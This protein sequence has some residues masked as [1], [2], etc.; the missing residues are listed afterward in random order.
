MGRGDSGRHSAGL[1][2]GHAGRSHLLNRRR[3]HTRRLSALDRARR[4]SGRHGRR[5][6]ARSRR[7]LNRPLG[8]GLRH[9]RRVL[10]RGRR[11]LNR[12]LGSGLR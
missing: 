10:A 11:T 3:R 7:T 9:L 4:G 8:S 6:L 5:V 12:P 2:A 1:S